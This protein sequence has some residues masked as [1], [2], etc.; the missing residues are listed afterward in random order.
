MHSISIPV[1]QFQSPFLALYF[2]NMIHSTNSYLIYLQC[3][4]QLYYLTLILLVECLRPMRL[5]IFLV[6]H[7]PSLMC[8]CIA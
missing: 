2:C 5:Q 1:Q 8:T 3:D 6:E 4:V 7:L